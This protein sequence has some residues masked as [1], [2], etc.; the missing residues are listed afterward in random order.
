MRGWARDDG[1][2]EVE[3]RVTDRKP[4]DFTSPK[5]T[6]I[7]PANLPIHDMG[8]RLVFDED[9]VVRAV[10]TFTDASP[11]ADCPD[12]GAALQALVGLRIG[13]GW[14]GEV[15]KRLGGASSCTH[16]RELLI[17]LATAAYQS[18]TMKRMDLPDQLDASGKPVKV[19]SCYAYAS[20]RGV[21]L[22]RW[23]DFYTGPERPPR[24][25]AG[26]GDVDSNA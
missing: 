8:V 23:P 9:M 4:H 14:S 2:F 26:A 7:V 3:G 6:K 25:P 22:H 12:G 21:V 15:R 11:Y 17:P 1:L 5:G 19:D 13:G 10:T 20:N 24:Q 16:L 18:M